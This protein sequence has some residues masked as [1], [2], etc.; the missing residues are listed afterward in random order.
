MTIQEAIKVMLDNPYKK[1]K[2]RL[3]APDEYIYSKGDKIIYD[4][5]GY[6]FEDWYSHCDGL[7][8]KKEAFCEEG[9]SVYDE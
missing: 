3:F 7:R 8:I 1:I 2:H 9:W 4:E 5:N 6:V